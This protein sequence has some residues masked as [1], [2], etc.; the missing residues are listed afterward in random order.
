MKRWWPIM[1]RK[2]KSEIKP[3]NV[4][5]RSHA[6]METSVQ[7]AR[8][9]T[10]QQVRKRYQLW[11]LR[12]ERLETCWWW[13]RKTQLINS[14]FMIEACRLTQKKEWR[15]R[16]KPVSECSVL[17]TRQVSKVLRVWTSKQV[18]LKWRVQG[19][20][21]LRTQGL[22]SSVR[23]TQTLWLS[24]ILTSSEASIVRLKDTK[25]LPRMIG[26]S[27][28]FIK[29][30]SRMKLLN[31]EPS[32]TT[33]HQIQAS[34][35]PMTQ[36]KHSL[37]QGSSKWF[38]K[39]PTEKQKK[40]SKWMLKTRTLKLSTQKFKRSTLTQDLASLRLIGRRETLKCWQWMK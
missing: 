9:R 30:L 14:H 16:C 12:C 24:P 31:E 11:S 35:H 4:F 25:T 36:T 37:L 34:T 19:T 6:P 38:L 2:R 5:S 29:K 40:E 8:E 20:K 1:K 27:R 3:K 18:R 17:K 10:G 23:L 13:M 21:P 33:L 28:T 26:R 7:S 15:L 39:T 22:I 32:I